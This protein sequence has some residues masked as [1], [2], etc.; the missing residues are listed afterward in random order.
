M[1]RSWRVVL[2][3]LAALPAAFACAATQSAELKPSQS[4]PDDRLAQLHAR[5]RTIAHELGQL[6]FPIKISEVTLSLNENAPAGQ[7]SRGGGDTDEPSEV[8]SGAFD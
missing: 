8:D 4:V 1:M 6:G 2:P 3:L 5:A 7:V